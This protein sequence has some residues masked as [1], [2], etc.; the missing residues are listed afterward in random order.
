MQNDLEGKMASP[1]SQSN[2]PITSLV[3][4]LVNSTLQAYASSNPTSNPGSPGSLL[5]F[6]FYYFYLFRRLMYFST[7]I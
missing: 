2:P 7:I 3:S 6:I 4:T 5:F 1:S